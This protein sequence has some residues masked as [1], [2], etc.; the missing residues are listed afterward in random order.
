MFVTLMQKRGF[1]QFGVMTAMAVMLLCGWVG[2]A[3][4]DSSSS[5]NYKVEGVQFGSGSG[6]SC[7]GNYCAQSSVGDTLAGTASSANYGVQFG[8]TIDKSPLLQVIM[9]G[10]TQ[11]LGVLDTDRT[12][13]AT[14]VVKVRDYYSRGYTMQMS[15]EPPTQ[16]THALTPLPSPTTSHQGAEQFGINLVAN[17][18]P[19]VGANPIQRPGDQGDFGTPTLDYAYPNLFKYSNNDTIASSQATNGETEYTISMI[20]NVSSTTPLGRYGGGFSIIVIPAF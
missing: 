4:A 13:T 2:V 11:N 10:N 17:D 8:P 19:E 7:S 14:N 12:A 15:G 1:R 16:G 20:I 3:A 9:I 5:P 6:D 18:A